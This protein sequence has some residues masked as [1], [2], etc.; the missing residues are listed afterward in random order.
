MKMRRLS[1]QSFGEWS[2]FTQPNS[3]WRTKSEAKTGLVVDTAL[4]LFN[5]ALKGTIYN[6]RRIMYRRKACILESHYNLLAIVASV[7][8]YAERPDPGLNLYGV[9]WGFADVVAASFGYKVSPT[10]S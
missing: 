1:S 5:A 3:N 10:M 6:L 9:V 7:L 8:L 2:H 4:L